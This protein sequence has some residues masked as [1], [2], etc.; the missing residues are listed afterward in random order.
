ME[1]L[2]NSW[3]FYVVVNII[4]DVIFTQNYKLAVQKA[5]ND[6]AATILMETIAGISILFLVPFFPFLIPTNPLLYLLLLVSIFFGS[7]QDRL[8][9]TARKILP[10][11]ESAILNQLTSA[12][13]ILIGFTIFRQPFILSKA[14]GAGLILG[15]NALLMYKKGKFV[16]NKDTLLFLT[17]CVFL[18]ISISLDIGFS[19]FFNIP[20]YISLVYLIA[21]W[22]IAVTTKTRVTMIKKEF[23]PSQRKY[24]LFTGVA[25]AIGFFAIIRAAQL[26]PIAVVIPLGTLSVLLN[27]LTAVHVH[28]EK[29]NLWKKV[30]M[31]LLILAGITLTV[32]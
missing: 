30:F 16:F 9:T 31:A 22:F 2:L 18:S 25:W 28:N 20:F 14:I 13:V 4:T 32:L 7:M 17:A 23:L 24:Y 29:S 8:K 1:T 12:F 26:G 19:K 15:A 21:A 11:S 6:S 3:Q 27:V 10:A 5:K